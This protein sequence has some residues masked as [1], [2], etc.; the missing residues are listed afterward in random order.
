M[1][2]RMIAAARAC[3]AEVERREADVVDDADAIQARASLP[4]T[5]IGGDLWAGA[6]DCWRAAFGQGSIYDRL[7]FTAHTADAGFAEHVRALNDNR[8]SG[9]SIDHALLDEVHYY[10]GGPRYDVRSSSTPAEPVAAKWRCAQCGCVLVGDDQVILS[11]HCMDYGRGNV[12][13]AVDLSAGPDT[14]A[15]TAPCRC[16]ELTTGDVA[17]YRYCAAH[18]RGRVGAIEKGR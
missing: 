12:I 4:R 7:M 6:P 15:I 14:T 17:T 8:I 18:G 10:G 3:A 16:S 2:T 11:A 13:A 9:R 1:D 5:M